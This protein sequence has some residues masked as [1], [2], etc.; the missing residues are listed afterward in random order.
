LRNLQVVGSL[1]ELC[2][3][4]SRPFTF[5]GSP[6][7]PVSVGNGAVSLMQT[8]L[9]YAENALPALRIKP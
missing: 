6:P 1:N 7:L 9:W 5:V 4:E 8:S 2:S 3:A